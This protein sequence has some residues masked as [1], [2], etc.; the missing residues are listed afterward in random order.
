MPEWND[1]AI[2]CVGGLGPGGLGSGP[3]FVLDVENQSSAAGAPIV[4]NLS[5]LGNS[6]IWNVDQ[7]GS[8]H[9]KEAYTIFN[10]AGSTGAGFL[11]V[12]DARKAGGQV[13]QSGLQ[14]DGAF[15]KDIQLWDVVSPGSDSHGTHYKI[16]NRHS[17]LLL[18]VPG[19]RFK[20]GTHVVED[21][22]HNSVNQLWYLG[23]V[24]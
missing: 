23:L 3:A 14:F 24:R 20:A 12:P 13:F 1:S 18:T 22:D 21:A 9:Y 7:P 17:G 15:V 6:Q 4:I 5:A 19:S 16:R 8:S 2:T 11:T 10:N